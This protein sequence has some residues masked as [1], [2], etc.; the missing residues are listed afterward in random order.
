M[1]LKISHAT[2]YS[3]EPE[4]AGV[5]QVLRL[6]PGSHD[7]QYVTEWR[8]D[9]S[10]D[11]RLDMRYDAFGNIAHV[12]SSGALPDLTVHVSGQVETQDTGGVLRGVV[13]RFPPGL[14]L[15]QTALTAASPDMTELAQ[16]LRAEAGEDVL[17]FL[18]ALLSELH[19]AIAF[20]AEATKAETSAKQAFAL[21]RGVSQDHA[22]AFIACARAAGVPARY[23]SGHYFRDGETKTRHAGH[24]WAEAFVPRL[25]WVGFDAATKLC[26]TEA[27]VR[28]AIGLD[29]LDAAPVRGARY[30][31]GA[32]TM[33]VSVRVD[34][35]GRQHQA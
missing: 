23:V 31:G 26:A 25:G 32:E 28:V 33:T 22:H 24:A 2:T 8:I 9:V 34:Q 11:A 35:A 29:Y 10:T 14:F 27:H 17:S 13:E 3:Y 19:D 1:R 20:D 18:H 30:G 7:G 4:T 21:G 5:I 12:F 16:T 6:T 15:R